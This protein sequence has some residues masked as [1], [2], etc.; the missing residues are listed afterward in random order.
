MPY[1]LRLL[2]ICM[3]LLVIGCTAPNTSRP[4]P[5]P[6]SALQGS[7]LIDG[8][9]T[10]A[11]ISQA[12]ADQFKARH[13]AVK[14]DV[15]ISGT[16]G[17]FKK[18]CAGATDISDASRPIDAHEWQMCRENGVTFIELPVAFDGLSVVVHPSN[19][20]AICLT[21]AELRRIWAPEAEGVITNW[22]HIRD[23]FPNRPL[24]LYGAGLDSGTYDYFTQA[25]VGVE[26]ESRLDY[27]GSEDDTKL[28]QGVAQD[29]NALGF[30]GYAYYDQNRDKLKLLSI[31]NGHGCIEPNTETVSRGLYQPLS[32][33]IFIYVNKERLNANP[34][35][36]AFVA[37]YLQ[38][39]PITS[40]QVG[41]IPL[42][43]QL[44]ALVSER[45][46]NQVE[47][48]VFDGSGALV[49]VSIV[50]LLA[51]ETIEER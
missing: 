42:T 32:R 6:T 35:L 11:P 49:G 39:A 28:V 13:P 40:L 30:F 29:P 51:S 34:A 36:A 31:D 46:A 18:F 43:D 38:H 7:I 17:G 27:F 8:S 41:Y 48:T 16:G 23:T 45:F 1:G 50:D 25:I 12:I 33:P 14:V 19:D 3:L 47:G 26:G 44:Y 20:W 15:H 2:A 5:S 24:S 21:V 10:V 37:F 9:S 22:K 4:S